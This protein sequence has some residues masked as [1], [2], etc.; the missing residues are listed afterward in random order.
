M[1]T[2]PSSWQPTWPWMQQLD[3]IIS[4]VKWSI[5][6]KNE[7]MRASEAPTTAID[8]HF[9][10]KLS[11]LPTQ[12][13]LGSRFFLVVINKQNNKNWINRSNEPPGSKKTIVM[14]A[15]IVMLVTIVTSGVHVR[16]KHCPSPAHVYAY[17]YVYGMPIRTCMWMFMFIWRF[18]IAQNVQLTDNYISQYDDVHEKVQE[19]FEIVVKIVGLDGSCCMLVAQGKF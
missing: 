3:S 5:D 9:N 11:N 15:T 19:H 17:M 7:K 14:F 8:Q 16:S 4:L 18:W 12:S 2:N 1:H 10:V 6:G 13:G